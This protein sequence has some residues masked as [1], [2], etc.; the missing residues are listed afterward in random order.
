[1]TRD[2][3]QSN[4]S[5]SAASQ[6][7]S[8][9]DMSTSA[10]SGGGGDLSINR[11][12]KKEPGNKDEPEKDYSYFEKFHSFLI[13]FERQTHFCPGRVAP[14][15]ASSTRA[16]FPHFCTRNCPRFAGDISKDWFS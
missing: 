16:S 4:L 9:H 15:K 13:E 1:M 11:A 12:N 10:Q 14:T 7:H 2:V 6:Y 5:V 8:V 3:S